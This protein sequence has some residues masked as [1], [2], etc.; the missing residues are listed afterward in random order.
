M[1]INMI[2]YCEKNK[3]YENEIIKNEKVFSIKLY[4]YE[5]K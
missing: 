2:L 5:R 3:S 4:S 1:K